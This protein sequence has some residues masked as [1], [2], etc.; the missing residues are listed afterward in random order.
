MIFHRKKGH[1]PAAYT[2]K[3]FLPLALLADKTFLPFAV[4]ILALKP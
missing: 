1:T 4:L 2:V 3:L